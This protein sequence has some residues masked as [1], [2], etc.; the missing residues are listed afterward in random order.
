LDHALLLLLLLL[1]LLGAAILYACRA[2]GAQAWF[3][4]SVRTDVNCGICT[5]EALLEQ[6]PLLGAVL[7]KAF[8][9]GEWRYEDENCHGWNTPRI[10]ERKRQAQQ[11][12]QA[13]EEEDASGTGADGGGDDGEDGE[14]GGTMVMPSSRHAL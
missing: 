3:H 12:Q 5:R 1:L 6:L 11:E 10:L 8:G 4:A 9:D 2:E 13:Q 7:R 14:R